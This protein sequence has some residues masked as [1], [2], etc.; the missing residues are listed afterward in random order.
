MAKGDR[1]EPW[2]VER[3]RCIYER[4]KSRFVGAC[5]F[6]RAP[7][8]VTAVNALDGLDPSK[9][10]DLLSAVERYRE[11]NAQ[12]YDPAKSADDVIIEKRDARVAM[13]RALDALRGLP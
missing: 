12:E 3:D 13:F 7:F 5:L 8:I 2:E 4:G 9:L 11:V 10:G 6:D 1:G